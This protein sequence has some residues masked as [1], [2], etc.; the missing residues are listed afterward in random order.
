MSTLAYKNSTQ[1]APSATEMLKIL[2]TNLDLIMVG[3]SAGQYY[4]LCE[5]VKDIDLL[6]SNNKNNI[7]KLYII[8]K[9]FFSSLTMHDLLKIDIFRLCCQNNQMIDLIYN[10]V[11]RPCNCWLKLPNYEILFNNSIRAKF[12][13]LE[14]NILGLQ[15]Y[16]STVSCMMECHAQTDKREKYKNILYKY[17]NNA[18]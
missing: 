15:D 7:D 2:S 8:L 4:G 3:S 12:L 17:I 11:V 14:I 9:P 13:N 18:N 5:D 1:N 16:I 6:L 10:R